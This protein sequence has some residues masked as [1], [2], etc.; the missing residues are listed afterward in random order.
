M[1]KNRSE[2]KEPIQVKDFIDKFSEPIYEDTHI[3][4]A[5]D[6]LIKNKLSGLP[7][8]DSSGMSVGYISQK[9]CMIRMAKVKYNNDVSKLVK[10]FMTKKCF[11]ISELESMLTAMDIFTKNSY[12]ILPVINEKKI[13][14]GVLTRE[15][16]F[17]YLA[18]I[19]QQTWDYKK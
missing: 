3:F 14:V 11:V 5:Q 19:E 8:V 13:I 4:K 17:K 6:I 7:V 2:K 10:D 16:I 1:K 18:S 12:H 15:K 9:D